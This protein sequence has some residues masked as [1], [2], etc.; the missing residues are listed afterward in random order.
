M[1]RSAPPPSPHCKPPQQDSA[2]VL[3]L[4]QQ[5]MSSIAA[6]GA[7]VRAPAAARVA[8][9][10]SRP[11][12]R[13]QWRVRSTDHLAD[14]LK[15][16]DH[17]PEVTDVLKTGDESAWARGKPLQGHGKVLVLHRKRSMRTDHLPSP[18]LQ[19]AAA[20]AIRRHPTPVDASIIRSRAA[21]RTLPLVPCALL[22]P[23]GAERAVY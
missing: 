23:R 3:T 6:S 19:P 14:H 16:V 11:C 15:S 5:S 2:D 1:A 13:A 20:A 8:A 21:P 7:C 18:P 10:S 12:A 17:P 4:L 22:R 9:R